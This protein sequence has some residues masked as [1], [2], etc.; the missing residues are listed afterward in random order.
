MSVSVDIPQEQLDKIIERKFG[1]RSIEDIAKE[2]HATQVKL[3]EASKVEGILNATKGEVK[4]LGQSNDALK[5]KLEQTEEKNASRERT[6]CGQGRAE[7]RPGGGRPSRRDPPAGIRRR[8]RAR[9]AREVVT[10][11][12]DEHGNVQEQVVL[13]EG[14]TALADASARNA[15]FE[16]WF[17][18]ER[19]VKGLDM[20]RDQ[21]AA[22]ERWISEQKKGQRP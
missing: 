7:A 4:R 22:F 5:A 19:Q 3:A 13:R 6:R 18:S 11:L 12:Y 14:E 2:L 20:T 17:E 16:E 21:P 1:G 9:G 15:A 8:R 10:R